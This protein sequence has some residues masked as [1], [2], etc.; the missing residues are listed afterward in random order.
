MEMFFLVDSELFCLIYL[1]ILCFHIST[2]LIRLGLPPNQ[3]TIRFIGIKELPNCFCMN[4]YLSSCKDLECPVQ[5]IVCLTAFSFLTFT[6]R[7][8]NQRRKDYCY[9]KKRLI[10]QVWAKSSS[11]NKKKNPSSHQPTKRQRDKHTFS[12]NCLCDTLV[13]W[14]S[15]VTH[16]RDA[17]MI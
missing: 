1:S 11:T 8:T 16:K 7:K 15:A 9:R 3:P 10:R 2:V 17:Y 14:K 5:T 6:L 12:H 4:R 13:R